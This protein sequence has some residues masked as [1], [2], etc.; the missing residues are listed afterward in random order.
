LVPSLHR[1]RRPGGLAALLLLCGLPVVAAAQSAVPAGNHFLCYE[2]RTADSRTVRIEVRDTARSESRRTVDVGQPSGYC[3]PASDVHR[4]NRFDVVDGDHHL[5]AYEVTPLD[6]PSPQA[7]VTSAFSNGDELMLLDRARWLMVPSRQ[8]FPNR[9]GAPR[10]LGNYLCYG[11][12]EPQDAAPFDRGAADLEDQF[13]RWPNTAVGRALVVCNPVEVR[14]GRR[15]TPVRDGA[16]SLV[17]YDVDRSFAGRAEG[18]SA[19]GTEV[20]SLTRA[21]ALCVPAAVRAEG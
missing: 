16:S 18:E 14:I 11:V 13:G 12:T 4:S 17:C 19:L 21:F 9:Q 5:V 15:V 7:V 6:P 1:P 3:D 10:G 20:V 8:S 2:G